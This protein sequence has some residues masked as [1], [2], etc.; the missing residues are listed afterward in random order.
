M[1]RFCR[2]SAVTLTEVAVASGC[3][4]DRTK[5]ELSPRALLE[6]DVG[7]GLIGAGANWARTLWP[8][9]PPP[10]R[11]RMTRDW[12]AARRSSTCAAARRQYSEP[13]ASSWPGTGRRRPGGREQPRRPPRPHPAP[14]ERRGPPRYLDDCA[15]V[16]PSTR[17]GSPSWRRMD[18]LLVPRVSGVTSHCSRRPGRSSAGVSL[19]EATRTVI[20]HSPLR[21]RG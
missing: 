5:A 3:L 10:R 8:T 11:G 18:S 20:K 4:V 21:W 15:G 16:E 12:S 2:G 7:P 9:S 13:C 6:R 14:P 1:S 17:P 19:K